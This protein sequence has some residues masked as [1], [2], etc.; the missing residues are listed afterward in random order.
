MR[1]ARH[2]STRGFTLLEVLVTV[3]IFALLFTVLM[4]GWFQALQAQSRL[5]AAAQQLQQQQQLAFSLRQLIAE[6]MSPRSGRGTA[7]TGTQRGFTAETSASL[8]PGM[9]AAPLATTLQIE[10]TA[11]ALA[12]HIA[13]PGQP[14]A[15]YPWRL[16]MAELRYVDASGQ[17]HER[18]PPD[19]VLVDAKGQVTTP[20]LLQLMLQFEGQ[21]RP[22][23]LLVAPRSSAWQ[24]D[25]AS[26]PFD[27][28]VE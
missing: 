7:F 15:I 20:P 26:S 25:E 2:G 11:P 19:S 23:T 8:A 13:H 14:N 3:T 18:W 24:L 6:V 9:G 4:A 28:K 21:A 27:T 10:G 5:A 1:S 16:V 17:A 22:M 12:I